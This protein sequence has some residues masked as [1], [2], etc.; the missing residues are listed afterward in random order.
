MDVEQIAQMLISQEK[1]VSVAEADTCGLVGYMLS[2]VPGSSRYFPGGVIAYTGG[3]KQKILG[4]SDELY[5]TKGSVS[6]EVAIAMARGVLELVG[7]DYALSTTG[8]TGPAQGRS[9]L[10]IGT[11]FVGLAVKDGED[12]AVEIHVSGDRD[13]TK[14]GATQAAID[15]LGRHLQ[16]A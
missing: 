16:G 12:T 9:G 6:R 10:A 7:T 11:F 3:L 5:N 2:T 13:A 8:V 15:L 14:H 4:V 1:T